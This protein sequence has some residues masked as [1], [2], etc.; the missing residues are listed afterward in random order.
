MVVMLYMLCGEVVNM[1]CRDLEG[2]E[3]GVAR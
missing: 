1:A 3:V 2:A